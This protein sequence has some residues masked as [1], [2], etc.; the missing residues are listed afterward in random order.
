MRQKQ[1]YRVKVD[2][3]GRLVIPAA[4]RDALMITPEEPLSLI[5]EDDQLRIV[6]L[7]QAI[8][9]AQAIARRHAGGR[10]G[11]VDEFLRERRSD[12]GE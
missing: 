9:N 6:T 11:L 12:S 4:A 1:S 3:Q 5:V 8:R 10:T 7:T 2:G